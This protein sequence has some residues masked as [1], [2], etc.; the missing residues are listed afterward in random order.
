MGH[1]ADARQLAN[2]RLLIQAPLQKGLG[3]QE[4]SPSPQK[5]IDLSVAESVGFGGPPRHQSEAVIGAAPPSMPTGADHHLL[6]GVGVAGDQAGEIQGFG[7]QEIGP[8][9]EQPAAARRQGQGLPGGNLQHIQVA[10]VVAQGDKVVVPGVATGGGR[11]KLWLDDAIHM[12]L[13]QQRSLQGLEGP[14]RIEFRLQ[15]HLAAAG[16]A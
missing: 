6:V 4:A 12:V 8:N 7:K 14:G 5:G 16:I 11:L 9:K 15:S 13:V 10:Q 2:R 3:V 1:G